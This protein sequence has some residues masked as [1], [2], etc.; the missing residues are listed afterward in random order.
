MNPPGCGGDR[1]LSVAVR[2][3]VCLL[4]WQW[5]M[6]ALADYLSGGPGLEQDG[7]DLT[8]ALR[9][10]DEVLPAYR[11][12]IAGWVKGQS[13]SDWENAARHCGPHDNFPS[14]RSVEA[15]ARILAACEACYPDDIDLPAW[16]LAGVVGD[17]AARSIAEHMSGFDPLVLVDAPVDEWPE[18]ID[19]RL[20]R[21]RAQLIAVLAIPTQTLCNGLLKIADKFPE[22]VVFAVREHLV[23]GYGRPADLPPEM[24]RFLRE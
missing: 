7:I 18:L 5:N 22:L 15:A 13:V 14:P 19:D 1:P 11:A 3:R 20:D 6:S 17:A 23:K 2:N 10:Y 8:M 4:P 24:R 12:A 21:A 9:K 16:L